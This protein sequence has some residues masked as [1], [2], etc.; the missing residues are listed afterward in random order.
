MSTG[1]LPSYLPAVRQCLSDKFL[2]ARPALNGV[3]PQEL[4]DN[5]AF[6]SASVLFHGLLAKSAD[7][8]KRSQ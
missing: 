7:P 2:L 4:L 3:G 5:K 1:C 6:A 8:L